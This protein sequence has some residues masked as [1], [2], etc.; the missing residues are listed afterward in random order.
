MFTTE[1]QRT[2]RIRTLFFGFYSGFLVRSVVKTRPISGEG[3]TQREK[4]GTE[5]HI[6]HRG[7]EYTED[8]DL[9]FFG[10]CSG[11]LVRLVVKNTT[12]LG[13]GGRRGSR[14]ARRNHVHHR[15]TETRRIRTLFFRVLLGVL[16]VFGGEKDAGVLSDFSMALWSP[17]FEKQRRPDVS[18]RPLTRSLY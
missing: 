5:N 11:F 16:G 18:G 9:I 3:R 2:R 1:A 14:S 6:H 17:A 10:F 12:N 8:S 15:G 4:E 7:A 13:E